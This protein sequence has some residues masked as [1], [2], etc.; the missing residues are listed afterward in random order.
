MLP[1]A[2]PAGDIYLARPSGNTIDAA[3]HRLTRK[4]KPVIYRT[5]A[6]LCTLLALAPAPA[7]AQDAAAPAAPAADAGK[8][9]QL[10]N[11][12]DLS[13]WVWIQGERKD[14]Q[15]EVT[16]NDV[17]SV[18]EGGVIHNKGRPG[19]YI[20]TEKDYTN[21]KLTLEWRF[22][23]K[24]GNGGVL[25]RMQPPDKVWPKSIEAQLQHQQAGDFWNIDEFPMKAAPERTKGRNTKKMHP[26]NEKP[27]GEW[28]RY[29]IIVDGGTVELKVNDLVQNV[30]TECEVIA[31]KICLQSEGSEMEFRNVELTELPDKKNA[32]SNAK[33]AALAAGLS[34]PKRLEGLDGW[35]ILGN[36][37][38]TLKDGIIEGKQ[39][40]S[41]KTYTHVVSDKSYRDF[42]ASLKFKAVKGNSG[43]YFRVRP[44]EKG[45]MHGIQAEIDELEN[46]G[47]LYESYGRQWVAKPDDEFVK[48]YFKPQDWNE[49]TVKARGPHVVV[50]VNGTKVSEINDS[51]VAMEGP[52][53]LQIHGG[54]DVHVMFKDIKI[55][56][57]SSSS[58]SSS[59]SAGA[60][61]AKPPASAAGSA[62]LQQLASDVYASLT[63]EQKKQATLPYDSPE[64][65][66]EIFNGGERAG[67]QIK[68]LNADQQQLAMSLLTGFTSDYGRRKAI[69]V[70]DQ[71]SNTSD[72]TTGFARYY[73]CFFGEPGAGKTYAWR[74]AEHHLTLVHMEVE[75]GE[76][77]SFGPI[78]LGANPPTLWD[79]EE[80]K[81]L[82]LYAA[83]TPEEKAK[84]Q[85]KQAK[86]ISTAAFK[87]SG[88]RV[89]ELSASAKQAAQA[90]LDHRLSFFSD[91]IAA[92][93]KKIIASQGGLDAMQIAYYGTVDKKC[94]DGGRWDFKLASPNAGFLCDY[95]GSRAHI[96]L[97]M[98]GKLADR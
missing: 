32:Q 33:P 60:A 77:T 80:E 25:L 86:G 97:S 63:P 5:F 48:T 17:W 2:N 52:F 40:E 72:P 49:M 28:N 95:E 20:R 30:A 98:K 76:P 92:R 70:S 75:S 8:P 51:T 59:N 73:L 9:V 67:V 85:Q 91:P 71:A 96:H 47:G 6:V 37:N 16:I 36:G 29:E 61:A 44:D 84:A 93:I 3:R 31:G 13:G 45:L 19:G 53:A 55:E 56:D 54:Q 42:K 58:S 4:E 74:I 7:R 57:L 66:K 11:G 78:L 89:G 82:A 83:M 27:L 24:P 22:P 26:S 79:E 65:T 21:F 81:L 10:F 15:P 90:V 41:E 18:K 94:R 34:S 14:G 62:S 35:H 1:T 39:P 87:G 50:H 46:A 69:E 43:F 88:V 68:S 64:R 12:K 23:A 38:W